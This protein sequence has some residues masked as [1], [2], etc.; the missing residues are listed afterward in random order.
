[1]KK[2]AIQIDRLGYSQAPVIVID[3]GSSAIEVIRQFAQ[4]SSF[5]N[6]GANNYPGVRAAIPKDMVIAYV[7][8]LLPYL[9]RVF[10]IPTH[11]KP[12]PL[13]N[14]FSLITRKNGELNYAQTIPHFDTNNSYQIAMVHYLNE[15]VFG[16][17]SF[18]KH[19]PTGWEYIDQQRRS[20]YLNSVNGYINSHANYPLSYCTAD[21]PL[22]DCY[23]T[24]EYRE[25]RL[26]VFN[27]FMLHSTAVNVDTDIEASPLTGRLTA[28]LFIRFE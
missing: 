25:N 22:F 18:Y 13:D 1:M 17:T 11:L 16:G 20:D 8:P 7:K 2:A 24:I 14:Y 23:K 15:G 9:Y 6:D 28:N 10:K 12:Q 5:D 26:I 3:G 27:G 19:V 4:N 21:H